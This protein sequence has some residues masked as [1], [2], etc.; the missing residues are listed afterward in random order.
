MKPRRQCPE[1][2][3]S[4]T[5]TIS[6]MPESNSAL[7]SLPPTLFKNIYDLVRSNCFRPN[8]ITHHVMFLSLIHSFTLIDS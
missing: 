4:S 2:R 8:R 7:L 6:D 1:Q 5:S 3:Q